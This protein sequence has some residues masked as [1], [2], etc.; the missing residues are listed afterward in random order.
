MTNTSTFH[1]FVYGS[2]R[3]GFRNPAYQYLTRFFT[4]QGE[5]LVK[6]RF[7]DKG[8]IPVA[9]PTTDDHFITGELYMINN[10]E[11]FTWA[12]EQLDDYEGI[13]VEAGEIPL[14]RRETTEAYQEG[15]STLSWIYWYNGGVEGLPEIHTGDVLKYLQQRNQ[16]GT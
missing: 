15:K 8:S 7:Y 2:L 3:S 9:V 6:G 16:P 4:L 13:H 11:E 1:L 10:P 14:Y 12:M 5:A